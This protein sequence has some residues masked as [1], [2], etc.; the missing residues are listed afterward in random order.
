MDAE[1][2]EIDACAHKINFSTHDS[3]VRSIFNFNFFFLF[4]TSIFYFLRIE[5][6]IFYEVFQFAPHS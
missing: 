1:N 2:P 5:E 4:S 3:R 6:V